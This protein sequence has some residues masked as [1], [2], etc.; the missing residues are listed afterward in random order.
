M[1]VVGVDLGEE[2]LE[3]VHVDVLEALVAGWFDVVGGAGDHY[4]V[5][6]TGE[7]CEEGHEFLGAGREGRESAAEHGAG[8]GVGGVGD[9]ETGEDVGGQ[10]GDYVLGG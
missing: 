1:S 5:F 8:E 6:V 9:L 7:H 4:V 10:V 2:A 3:L